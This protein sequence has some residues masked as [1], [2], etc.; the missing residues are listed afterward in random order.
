MLEKNFSSS[1]NLSVTINAFGVQS[2][3]AQTRYFVTLYNYAIVATVRYYL[4]L[5]TMVPRESNVVLLIVLL[6]YRKV[7]LDCTSG[8]NFALMNEDCSTV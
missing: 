3:L 2:E 8:D 6:Q 7:K 5:I 1:A 4:L